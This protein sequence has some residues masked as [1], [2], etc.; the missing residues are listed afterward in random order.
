MGLSPLA[1]RV[2]FALVLLQFG[3]A[4][5]HHTPPPYRDDPESAARLEARA[6]EMCETTRSEIDP[7]PS[8]PFVTDGCSSWPDGASYVECCV[9]H[10]LRYWCGGSP[11][12]RRDA[13]SEFGQC[14]S[15]GGSSGLGT[16]MRLG[17]R[18]G[19]HPIFPTHYRWGYGHP[20]RWGYPP[21]PSAD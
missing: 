3:C 9:E 4:P 18:F 21:T 10:D 12:E 1:R 2:G 6:D 20:Y 5:T 7:P 19:G 8:R 13:D 11:S 16:M 17:V 15:S 14:V